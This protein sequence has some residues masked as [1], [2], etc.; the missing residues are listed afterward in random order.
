M[1][2]ELTP[3]QIRRFWSH[4]ARSDPD[5]CW[6]WQGSKS[7]SGYGKVGILGKLHSAHRIS[8]FLS[9]GEIPDGMD[10]CHNCP[11]GDHRLCVNPA[12]LFLG[13]R[14][15]N[16]RDA[17]AKGRVATGDRHG[18]RKHP[19]RHPMRLHPELHRVGDRNWA[20][21]HPELLRRGEAAA[22]AKLTAEM[23]EGVRQDQSERRLSYR[24]IAIK[25]G[26]SSSQVYRIVKGLSWRHT[27]KQ[28]EPL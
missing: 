26:I 5:S 8:Y 23:V 17:V 14:L 3:A 2:P 6:L 20:R 10:V 12:H 4:V 19:E 15:E 27:F 22:A 9:H 16:M 18:L 7:G 24:Q 21:Q 11:G 1:I 25:Y 13:S 28:S